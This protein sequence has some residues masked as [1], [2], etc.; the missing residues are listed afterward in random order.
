MKLICI[1]KNEIGMFITFR[2]IYEDDV[3][4]Y[5]RLV[6]EVY[7]QDDSGKMNWYPTNFFKPLD[8]FRK[9]QIDKILK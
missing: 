5:P 8:E 7:I 9:E 1:L 2:K 3:T 4:A 6:G